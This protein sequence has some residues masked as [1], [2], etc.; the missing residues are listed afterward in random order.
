MI[1]LYEE[2]VFLQIMIP[3]TQYDIQMDRTAASYL[4]DLKLKCKYE[5]WFPSVPPG[6]CRDFTSH[7]VRTVPFIFQFNIDYHPNIHHYTL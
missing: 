3:R 4:E 7:Y 1:K 5:D 2:N 6:K